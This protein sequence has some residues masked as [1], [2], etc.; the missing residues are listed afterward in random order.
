MLSIEQAGQLARRLSVKVSRQGVEVAVPSAECAQRERVALG[1]EGGELDVIGVRKAVARIVEQRERLVVLGGPLV[2]MMQLAPDFEPES[3]EV[4]A[5]RSGVSVASFQ[6]PTFDKLIANHPLGSRTGRGDP[7]REDIAGLI[8]QVA[9]KPLK[10]GCETQDQGIVEGGGLPASTRTWPSH[11]LVGIEQVIEML[12]AFLSP[13]L[14]GG[15]RPAGR[16]AG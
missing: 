15:A 10:L 16:G 14:E 1:P 2:S 12:P 6:L 7:C 3:V 13:D 5:D 4:A 11:Q 8:M 9:R